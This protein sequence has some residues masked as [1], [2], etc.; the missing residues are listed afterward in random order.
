MSTEKLKR[1][2]GFQFRYSSQEAVA[3][4]INAIKPSSKALA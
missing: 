2:V 1:E 4:F 3:A